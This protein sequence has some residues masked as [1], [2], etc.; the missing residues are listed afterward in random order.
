MYCKKCGNEIKE[1]QKFCSNCGTQVLEI[2]QNNFEKEDL[3]NNLFKF[4]SMDQGKVEITIKDNKLTISRPGII[5][6]LSHGFVGEKTIL[7]NQISAVQ[8][9]KVGFSRGYLQFMISGHEERKSG[10]MKGAK[11][12]NI[13]YFDN[14]GK[15][16]NKLMNENAEYIKNYIEEY[17][18]NN[19]NNQSVTFVQQ[20]DKYDK[21]S[22]LKKLLDENIINQ[23]EFDKEKEKILNN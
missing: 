9:K 11:D 22:K 6:K 1:N 21:L 8:L 5:S 7:I 19:I 20:D 23:D 15:K 13:V 14:Y 3:N 4:K 2:E 16:Q 10:I 18:S 12:E 17:N